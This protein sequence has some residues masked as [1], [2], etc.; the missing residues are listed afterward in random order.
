MIK[1]ISRGKSLAEIKER[2]IH[3]FRR[4]IGICREG[5]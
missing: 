1:A 5:L 3:R 2:M 4:W